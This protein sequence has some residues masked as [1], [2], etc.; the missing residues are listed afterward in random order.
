MPI[1]RAQVVAVACNVT[2]CKNTDQF[3]MPCS[4]QE[5]GWLEVARLGDLSTQKR[6][7][8]CPEHGKLLGFA[9]GDFVDAPDYEKVEQGFRSLD[10][11]PFPAKVLPDTI[12]PAWKRLFGLRQ[13]EKPELP[14]NANGDKE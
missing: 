10:Q 1:Q 5:T 9:A 2:G 7:F 6:V 12:P 8:V 11:V 3:L 14:E 4:L 13:K